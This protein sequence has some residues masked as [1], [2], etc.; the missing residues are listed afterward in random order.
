MLHLLGVEDE[1]FGCDEEFALGAGEGGEVPEVV[2]G[3]GFRGV[4]WAGTVGL[5]EGFECDEGVV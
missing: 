2:V 1:L 5:D 3:E 4:S